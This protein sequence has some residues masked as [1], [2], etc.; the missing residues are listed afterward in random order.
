MV[1]TISIPATTGYF[2]IGEAVIYIAAIL[3]GPYVG[4]IAGGVGAAISDALLAP[5]FWPGTL[6]IKAFEGAIVGFLGRK[7]I[8]AGSSLRWKTFTLVLGLITG[9]LLIIIGVFYYTG[10]VQ[11]F[12]GIPPPDS[13]T[14]SFFIPA[15]FWYILGAL[16]IFLTAYA[17][18][19]LEPKLGWLVFAILLGGLEMVMGYFIYERLI[20]GNLLALLEIPV[21]IGQV[22]IGLIVAIPVARAVRRTLP[23]LEETP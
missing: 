15:E 10:E 18:F 1:F 3:F 12:W 23:I 9:I 11:I 13:P 7:A 2:N 5:V 21:N 20:L 22:L 6:F 4:A 16:V 8:K 17:G 14:V 19:K